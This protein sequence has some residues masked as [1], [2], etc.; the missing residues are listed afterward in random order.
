MKYLV[1]GSNGQLGHALI[2]QLNHT[3]NT[4]YAFDKE[5][6][7]ISD[8]SQV[9]SLFEN[10][11]VDFVINCAAFTNVDLCENEQ[12]M[13][14]KINIDAARKLAEQA[15]KQK[16]KFIHISTDFVFDGN[17]STP[18]TEDDKINPINFYGFTK[19]ESENKVFNE[20]NNCLVVRTSS[21]YSIY[22]SNFVK[23]IIRNG[24]KGNIRVVD[25]QISCPTSS[26]YLA[27]SIIK[28]INC[29]KLGVYNI[30]NSGYCSKF[31][32]AKFILNLFDIKTNLIS[33]SSDEYKSPA[34]RPSFSALDNQ[35]F[36]NEVS[37]DE[38]TWQ[39]ALIDFKD[40]YYNK[41]VIL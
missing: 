26:D 31:E 25:D 9:E 32:F 17:K 34:K 35:K 8:Y 19:A 39:Q 30:T 38:V 4:I 12:E 13:A 7:D 41:G 40:K 14:K 36:R 18:Y 27:S 15:E 28:L 6:L 5:N 11:N 21:V 1:T 20:T 33:C 23:S 10:I 3:K 29:N 2:N 16:A 24:K 22:N 37:S